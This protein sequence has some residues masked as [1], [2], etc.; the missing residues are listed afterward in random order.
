MT[1][2]EV[3][4]A[5]NQA[6]QKGDVAGISSLVL[7]NYVQHTP[8]V[9]DGRSGLE[10]LVSKIENKEMPGPTIKNIRTLNDGDFVV[11]HHDVLWPNRKVMFEIFRMESGLAAEHWSGIM[12][13]PEKTANGHTMVDGA[14]AVT[15]Q[16]DTQRNKSFVRDFVQ[17]ILVE[18]QFERILEFYHPEIIQ[19]NPFIDNT[20]AGLIKGIQE[21]Q[22]NGLT[23]QIQKIRMVLGE[24]N[25]VLTLSEGLFAGKP[26]AFFDLFRVE[27][28]KIVEHWDVLQEIP[29]PEKQAH[30]NGFF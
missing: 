17:T 5:V 26:T 1:N 13:H 23:I 14:T 12:E 15:N 9:A 20:V 4:H 7:E 18:G 27:S 28:G 3:A 19:H 22:K 10:A 25:F 11:L 30:K 21:L 16:I 2:T 29:T 8:L 6:V 24:G